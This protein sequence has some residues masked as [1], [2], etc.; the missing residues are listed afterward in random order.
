MTRFTDAGRWQRRQ[1][2][3]ATL[4]AYTVFLSGCGGAVGEDGTGAYEPAISVGPV[5]GLAEGAISVNGVSYTVDAA[6]T[7][8]DGFGKPLSS[9][10]LR[11]G[12]WVEISGGVNQAAGLG[13][14]ERVQ[15]RN[16]VRG[17]VTAVEGSA[18]SLGLTVLKSTARFAAG[19][20]VVEG[21]AEASA[22]L[23]GDL[24]E[25]HGPLGAA[26]G[27]VQATRVE[28]LAAAPSIE[29]RGRVSGLDVLNRRAVIGR[30]EINFAQATQTLRQPI[31]NNQVLRVAAS[32]APQA[33][34]DWMVERI[35]SDTPLPLNLG[36]AYA[37]GVSSNWQT[38]PLFE[39]DGLAVDGRNANNRGVVTANEQR[40]AAIGSINNGV[41]VAKSLAT[42]RPGQAVVF[43]LSGP[44]TALVSPAEFRVRN[45]IVDASTAVF[46]AGG[47]S[48]LADGKKVRVS[49][50]LSGQRL[51]AS[52]LEFL[53]A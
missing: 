40:V 28:R 9:N 43:N 16:S 49:G 42:V 18:D 21:V 1:L 10:A 2:L 44:I 20:T 51:I 39:L 35:T 34:G 48:D 45:V 4:G 14:A 17:V 53:P 38:G 22:L 41:L 36:F 33:A 11:L 46:T 30:Q 12:Q 32:S 5:V 15:V 47:V 52:K 25:V 7:V 6:A 26:A 19:Q 24:I 27:T 3:G 37:E 31:A 13:I 8:L 23:L 29:L 50:T